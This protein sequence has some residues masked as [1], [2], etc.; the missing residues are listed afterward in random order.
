MTR[1]IIRTFFPLAA[2]LASCSP[3]L[4][5]DTPAK[6]ETKG[7][8]AVT[9]LA[10]L[11]APWAIAVLPHGGVLVVAGDDGLRVDRGGRVGDDRGGG[12]SG[13]SGAGPLGVCPRA[14]AVCAD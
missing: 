2:F 13:G 7:V 8:F 1:T 3:S 5:G 9:P 6:T 10:T 14:G 12:L 11:D 4:A